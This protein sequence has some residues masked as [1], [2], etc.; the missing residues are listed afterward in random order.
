MTGLGPAAPRAGSEAAVSSPPRALALDFAAAA[1]A[2][3][4]ATPA[5]AA[6]AAAL[7]AERAAHAAERAA[8]AETKAAHG[9]ECAAHAV[10]T[11]QLGNTLGWLK[12]E[13]AQA[14]ANTAVCLD[15]TVI[16]LQAGTLLAPPRRVSPLEARRALAAILEAEPGAAL[17]GH[18]AARFIAPLLRAQCAPPTT[19][20]VAAERT[21]AASLIA[22]GSQALGGLPDD[23][24]AA[25][26]HPRTA[27]LLR[28]GGAID[29]A[30]IA[31]YEASYAAAFP[32]AE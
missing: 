27:A 12:G 20:R 9:A 2:A 11:D 15:A 19:W 16:M 22:R 26:L 17:A 8:H 6:L 4:E 21:L 30:G 3:A 10:T 24:A 7:A 28:G 5:E 32:R 18:P 29:A 13:I 25:L 14:D 1:D 31:T 23:V